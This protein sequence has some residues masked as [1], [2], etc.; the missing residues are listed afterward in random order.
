MGG[1]YVKF[2]DPARLPALQR[3]QAEIAGTRAAHRRRRRGGNEDA[4]SSSTRSLRFARRDHHGGGRSSPR[5]RRGKTQML[6]REIS[7]D[8]I[9][10]AGPNG[11]IIHYRV[12][13]RKQPQVAAHELY[14]V[15][16]GAQYQTAR[17]TSRARATGTPTAEMRERYTLVLKGMIAISM[18]RFPPSVRAADIDAVKAQLALW[19][20]TSISRAAWRL[21]TPVHE[22]PQRISKTGTEKA[23][24]MILFQRAR[25]LPARRLW[26]SHREPDLGHAGR[27]DPRRSTSPCTVSRR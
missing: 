24:G 16:S 14:L 1:T 11:A 7:F 22:G 26:H 5:D 2:A 3:N 9:S 19:K 8:T 17:P 27:G 10:G 4:R 18:L 21:P 25:L 15:D 23:A 13:D 6:L 12:P 20:T